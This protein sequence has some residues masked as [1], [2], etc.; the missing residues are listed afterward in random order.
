MS[1]DGAQLNIKCILFLRLWEWCL[2]LS[3][4]VEAWQVI[5]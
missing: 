1:S 4:D 2:L 5:I 3:V